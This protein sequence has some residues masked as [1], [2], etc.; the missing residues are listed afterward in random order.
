MS[1][2]SNFPAISPALSLDFAAVKALDP[3]ITY[4]R[5]STA[6][7]YGTQTAKAE[8]NLLLQSQ[9]FNISP[10][11]TQQDVLLTA[12]TQA[13]PNGTSTADTL[14]ENTA[15]AARAITDTASYVP[16]SGLSFTMSVYA[17]AGT[18]TV[19][20][21]VGRSLTFGTNVWANFD[22]SAGTVGSVG[23]LTTASIVNVG[24]GW[25]RC[26]IT[27]TST[28][29]GYGSLSISMVNNNASATRFPVYTGTSQLL[30]IWGA[31]LEQRSSVTAYTATTTQPITNYIPVLM[32]AASGVA[33][34]DHNPVTQESLGLLIEE[35]RTNLLTYSEQFD[36]AAW[37]KTK[38]SITANTIIAPDGTLTGDKLVEDSTLGEHYP[39]QLVSLTTGT[40]YTGS[41]YVKAGERT[42]IRLQAAGGAFSTYAQSNAD[43][44]L[45]T[46]TV[47]AQGS[48]SLGATITSVGNGWFRCTLSVATVATSTGGIFP[49][50]SNGSTTSY[51]GNG[52][53]GIYIWGAQ[54]E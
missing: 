11:W 48:L 52:Y 37:T 40:T 44:N 4:S 7:Y 3:R 43:F 46:G 28:A 47:T 2:A 51:T 32:T 13:A 26:V 15:N 10:T 27:G 30:Y 31:Q 49:I 42:S 34:F 35:Q 1:I 14:T 17:K 9:D 18:A 29:S 19:I 8:E 6:T 5:A 36:N 53:S 12:N 50:L 21:L 39:I 20:Q 16:A 23:S 22:L 33:R 41:V 54:L 45:A 38:S 24:S 25:Y